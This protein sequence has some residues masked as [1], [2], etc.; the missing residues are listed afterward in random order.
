MHGRRTAPHVGLVAVEAD[1]R[2]RD[3]GEAKDPMRALALA[4]KMADRRVSLGIKAPDGSVLHVTTFHSTLLSTVATQFC[5][6]FPGLQ[7]ADVELRINGRRLCSGLSIEQNGLGDSN[8]IDAH[9]DKIV[10]HASALLEACLWANVC[11]CRAAA[12]RELFRQGSTR[13]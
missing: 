2:A 3:D 10:P 13:E 6:S 1:G 9:F 8:Q 11:M 4:S 5:E 7:P 12:P